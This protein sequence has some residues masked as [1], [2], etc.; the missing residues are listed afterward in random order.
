MNTDLYAE[1]TARIIAAL[2]QGAPPW[3]RPWS[4]IP[5]AMPMNA[6]SR[7]TVPGDQLRSAFPGRRT[8]RIRHQS[9]A[10]VPSSPRARRARP[11]GRAGDVGCVLAP[12]PDRC[13][14]G[15]VP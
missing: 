8:T 2:E 1:T 14:R 12:A 11:Q 15:R 3:I 9:L 7:L 5:D 13:G 4:T 6:Q 10:D